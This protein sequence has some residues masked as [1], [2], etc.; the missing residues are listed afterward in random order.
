MSLTDAPADALRLAVAVVLLGALVPIGR[1]ERLAPTPETGIGVWYAPDAPAIRDLWRPGDAGDRL[2][3]R[4][5][6]LDRDGTPVT[7]ARVELWHADGSGMV[8]ADRFRTSLMTGKDGGV[9]VSTVLPG[10]I[11]GPRHVHVVVTHPEH[12]EFISRIFFKR[13]PVVADSG[14]PD[15]AIFLEDGIVK[16]EPV[17]FGNMELVLPSP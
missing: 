8:H 7:G 14:H 4:I 15:L 17:L 16:G 6:V 11:W 13:D 3:L 10:Y 12:E 5:R 1:A 2:I 9:E